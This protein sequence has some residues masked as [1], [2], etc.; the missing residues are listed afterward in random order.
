[1]SSSPVYHIVAHQSINQSRSWWCA[2]CHTFSFPL[3][4]HF[5]PSRRF[6]AT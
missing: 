2:M 3:Y 4:F 1:M 5:T 6:Y